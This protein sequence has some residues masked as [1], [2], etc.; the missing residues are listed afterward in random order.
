MNDCRP[1]HHSRVRSSRCGKIGRPSRL[2]HQE[3]GAS[4]NDTGS[5]T[6]LRTSCNCEK[7]T[8]TI[9]LWHQEPNAKWAEAT[10]LEKRNSIVG[11][12]RKVCTSVWKLR[13]SAHDTDLQ[14]R[15]MREAWLCL[16]PRTT[17]MRSLYI[18]VSPAF[19]CCKRDRAWTLYEAPNQM[20]VWI[21]A[22]NFRTMLVRNFEGVST[23]SDGMRQP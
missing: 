21:Q 11:M 6:T 16:H 3:T 17:N 20:V 13:S 12:G 9:L 2:L 7:D 19:P 22:L 18:H 1:E 8:Q 23:V 15:A 5:P 4:A 14:G 10:R